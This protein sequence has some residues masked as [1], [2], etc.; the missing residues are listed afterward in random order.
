MSQSF[1]FSYYSTVCFQRTTV[2]LFIDQ[3]CCRILLGTIYSIHCFAYFLDVF[4]SVLCGSQSIQTAANLHRE[5]NWAVQGKETPWSTTSCVCYHGH[6]IQEY[7]ARWV[8]LHLSCKYCHCTKYLMCTAGVWLPM[9]QSSE[10]YDLH[11]NYKTCKI[12]NSEEHKLFFRL[13]ITSCPFTARSYKLI[14]WHAR[15]PLV[16]INV[17]VT[18]HDDLLHLNKIRVVVATLETN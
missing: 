14:R 11:H 1:D 17:E 16:L 18:G 10:S 4:W 12:G 5:S 2:T 13:Q 9:Q 3:P 15:A 8:C 6:G 7:V